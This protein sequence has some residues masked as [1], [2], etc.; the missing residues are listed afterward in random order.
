MKKI[1]IL[2][3]VI[4]TCLLVANVFFPL[5]WVE[6]KATAIIVSVL[7]GWI[8]GIAT[9][10]VGIIAASQTKKYKQE[11]DVFIEKQYALEKSKSLIQS[12]LL[13]V[14]NLKRMRDAFVEKANPSHF[15]TR[16]MS[17]DWNLSTN[18]NRTFFLGVFAECL[19]TFKSNY[20]NLEYALKMDYCENQSKNNAI[21]ALKEYQQVFLETFSNKALEEM[22]KRPKKVFDICVDVL[23]N[24]FA[25]TV[26]ALN[27]YVT[28]C[29]YDINDTIANKNDDNEYIVLH[30]APKK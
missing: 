9:L 12:R 23:S 28:L 4:G 1:I 7:S 11:N 13:F 14:D 19:F 16:L 30:Y 29:D 25:T 5:I 26:D 3:S 21:E 6:N 8:S 10:L 27:E 17:V 2:S 18:E 20:R 24:K 15:A 22:I